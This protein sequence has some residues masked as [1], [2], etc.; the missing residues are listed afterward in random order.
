M[1]DKPYYIRKGNPLRSKLRGVVGKIVEI[2]EKARRV[3]LQDHDG[4]ITAGIAWTD[5]MPVQEEA[6]KAARYVE[7]E[8][9][10]VDWFDQSQIAAERTANDPVHARKLDPSMICRLGATVA[11]QTGVLA[12]AY[13]NADNPAAIRTAI[14][15]VLPARRRSKGGA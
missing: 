10:P 7:S 6:P 9:P 1:S 15:R 3:S 2:D 12:Y 4:N 5:V 8:I 11:Y 13:V 14:D